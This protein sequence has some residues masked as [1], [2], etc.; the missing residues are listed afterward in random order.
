MIRGEIY[1]D[2]TFFI[3]RWDRVG[4]LPEIP[5]D[6]PGN[7]RVHY[8]DAYGSKIAETGFPFLLRCLTHP[9]GP[10]KICFDYMFFT[11]AIPDVKGVTKFEIVL[12]SDET[13]IP[14]PNKQLASGIEPNEILCN[15]D[16]QLIFKSTDGSPACVKPETVPKLIERGWGSFDN[17]QLGK[18]WIATVPTQAS[19]PYGLDQNV[20]KKYYEKHGILV[21]DI[22]ILETDNHIHCEAVGCPGWNTLFLLIS[23]SDVQK[24]TDAGFYVVPEPHKKYHDDTKN[25]KPL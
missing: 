23:N 3:D 22:V 11:R 13:K 1:P 5:L 12:T 19:N 15:G 20:I 8:L 21:Y 2:G 14:S 24:M 10:E 18:T 9:T 4:G 7:V 16:L 25:P 6:N 17:I